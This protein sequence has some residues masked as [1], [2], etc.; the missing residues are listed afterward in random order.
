MIL[1]LDADLVAEPVAV[2][3]LELDHLAGGRSLF[4]DGGPDPLSPA[5]PIA[6]QWLLSPNGLLLKFQ[7]GVSPLYARLALISANSSSCSATSMLSGYTRLYPFSPATI[8]ARF[9]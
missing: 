1:S 2:L 5:L 3:E 7:G 6:E 8:F 9:W 4:H